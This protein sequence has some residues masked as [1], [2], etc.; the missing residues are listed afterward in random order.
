VIERH[1]R[2]VAAATALPVA[3]HDYPSEFG[4]TIPA[5]L[6]AR[7]ANDGVT[8]YL[9]AED[10]PVLVKQRRILEQAPGASGSSEASA[11][12]GCSRSSSTAPR[13]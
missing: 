7:L 2:E 11:A 12:S 13:A 3:I 4:I 5:D 9:K 10:P 6:I 8:P 1:Y